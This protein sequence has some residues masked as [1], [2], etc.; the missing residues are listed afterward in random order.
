MYRLLPFLFCGL[1]L[2]DTQND[3]A[4]G[5]VKH[6]GGTNGDESDQGYNDEW[7]NAF[8]GC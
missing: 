2:C 6:R 8:Q 7:Q 4:F 5:P 1:F 3:R